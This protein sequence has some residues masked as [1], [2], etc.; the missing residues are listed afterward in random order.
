M[1]DFHGQQVRHVSDLLPFFCSV[2]GKS[3][4]NKCVSAMLVRCFHIFI[5]VL[6]GISLKPCGL[7]H[8]D[9]GINH[10]NKRFHKKISQD[11]NSNH[12]LC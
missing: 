3:A 10:K 7:D 8:L 11:C 12:K 2:Q 5:L 9:H 4:V 1:D 6:Y